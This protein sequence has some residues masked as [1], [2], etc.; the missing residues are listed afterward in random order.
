MEFSA[1]INDR[2]EITFFTI[3]DA[4]KWKAWKETHRGVTITI[5]EGEPVTE[6]SKRTEQQNRALH[7]Y[8][9][10]VAQAL[11]DAGYPIR[12]TLAR[13]SAELDWS[14]DSVKEVIWR[15]VQEALLHKRSTT[16]L[17]KQE[18]ITTIY[19]HVNRFLAQMGIHV[20]FPSHPP[21]YW[22]TAPMHSE[23]QP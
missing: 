1:Y 17:R 12:K 23:R 11:N 9:E 21:D 7:K 10:L 20:E 22:E 19:E 14:K 2:D 8:F 6:A 15:P 16:E 3:N 13:Y 5:T 18:D 4:A